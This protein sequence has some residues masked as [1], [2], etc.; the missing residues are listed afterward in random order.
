M[1]WLNLMTAFLKRMLL[2]R[3]DVERAVIKVACP[4]CG[5]M[6]LPTT[7]ENTGGLCMACKQG[8]RKDLENS[9]AYYQALKLYD[10][11]RELWLSLVKRCS[12]DST[13][14]NMSYEERTYFVVCLLEGEIYNG[15]LD[16][17]FTNSAGDYYRE[18]V[19][20]LEII[21]AHHS[22][23]IVREASEFIFSENG[24]PLDRMQRCEIVRSA[25]E[26]L[27]Q[28]NQVVGLAAQLDLLD[29]KFYKDEDG[30]FDLLTAYA[31]ANNLTKPFERESKCP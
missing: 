13:L 18:A 14:G 12:A 4:E 19:A 7:A 1:L 8:I 23:R 26:K 20:G 31:A 25:T 21:G 16:Q 5:A 29:K 2:P 27:S 22:L 6:I 28:S 15:G 11:V 9:K 10:P 3:G 30:L 24:P 17:F